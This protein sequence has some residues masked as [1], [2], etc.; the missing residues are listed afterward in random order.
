MRF[1]LHVIVSNFTIPKKFDL[2]INYSTILQEN[3]LKNWDLQLCDLLLHL[4]THVWE[5]WKVFRF[6]PS[7]Y[8]WAYPID[9]RREGKDI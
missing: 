8:L 9:L 1:V 2:D 3:P 5:Q 7:N 4:F 6:F